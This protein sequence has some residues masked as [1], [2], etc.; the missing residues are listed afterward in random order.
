MSSPIVT[1]IMATYNR[2]NILGF[3]ISTVIWQTFGDW[4]L[5]VIGDACTDETESVVSGFADDRIRFVNLPKNF[6]EQSGPNNEGLK[7]ARGEYIA[8]LNH[9]DLWFF[10]HLEIGLATLR[11]S[12]AD[13]ALASSIVDHGPD[14]A[15]EILGI[16][17][18]RRDYHPSRTFV[19]AS[20]WLFRR[21]MIEDIGFWS[22]A[23]E[24]RMIP[25][26]DWLHRVFDA[27]KQIIFTQRITVIAI[28]S[29]SRKNVYRDRNSS[30]NRRYFSEMSDPFFR[31]RIL[32][33]TLSSWAQ[34]RYYDKGMY[35]KRY[36]ME[37]LK[38]LAIMIGLSPGRIAH[39][40]RFNKGEILR[41]Y[42]QRRGLN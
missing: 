34:H 7:M 36:W 38:S 15:T 39:R 6:G 35:F 30:E 14:G 4:E 32:N 41:N 12:T 28:P 29:S 9:D 5:L 24:I 23:N 19:P 11:G 17:D 1:V 27:G 13:L 26:F 42:R 20:N 2:S 22:P 18:K 8:F 31:E 21:Q 10:D 3:A 37:K 16:P 25:S 40:V 33:E